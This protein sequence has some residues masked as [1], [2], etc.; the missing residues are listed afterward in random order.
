VRRIL[1]VLGVVVA[2]AG[3]AILSACGGSGSITSLDQLAGKDFA[4]P[5]GTIADQLVLSRFA[6]AKFTYFDSALDCC[7]AVKDGKADA[8][9][10]DQPVL[11]NIAAKNE[12][13]AVLPE[14]IT[15]DDYGIAV[16]LGNTELQT[17]IDS[18]VQRLK[19]DGTYDQMIARWLP[20]TGAP[21]A[22]PEI[23]L[24]GTNGVLKLATA[25]VTEPFS[26]VDGS[27]EVVGFDIELATYVA[28]ELG[29]SLEIVSMDFGEMLPKVVAGEV[30]MA[31]AC[32]TI[33]AERSKQV[34][35]SKPYYQGGIAAL[36]KK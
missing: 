6:D 13:L 5:S 33:S 15:V 19:S 27:Q 12:G 14:L 11:L 32:I 23:S 25:P 2:M 3:A 1:L 24:E 29:M 20:K 31:A 26:F 18:V 35:F 17:T 34:L 36:V 8:A 30:D 21:A 22:M 16:A 28:Q 9:A 4:V 7:L 10:Y